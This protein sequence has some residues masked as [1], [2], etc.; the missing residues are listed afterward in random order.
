MSGLEYLRAMIRGDQPRAP[1][2]RLLDFALVEA[3]EGGAAFEVTPGEQ[4]YNP[5]GVGTTTC[6]LM[7]AD[8][9]S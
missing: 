9:S 8:P 4:H 5:I 7:T 6:L 2:S 3:S 1:I